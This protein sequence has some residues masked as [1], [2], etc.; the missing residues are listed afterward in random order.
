[1]SNNNET[2]SM[3]KEIAKGEKILI[4]D[5]EHITKETDVPSL[6][7]TG[8]IP[9]AKSQEESEDPNF[10]LIASL[11]KPKDV[12]MSKEE[13][14]KIQN[15]SMQRYKIDPHY[16]AVIDAFLVFIIGKGLQ[17]SVQDEN[18]EVQDY[19]NEFLAVN[20]FNGRDRQIIS[21]V[22]KTGECFVRIFTK[23]EGKPARIPIV[24]C[25]NYWQIDDVAIDQNDNE[26]ILNYQRLYRDEK[27][28]LKTEVISSNEMM[29]FKFGDYDDA[30]GLPP[31]QVIARSC[32]YYSDWLMNRIVFNRL[33]TS[34]YLEEIVDGSPSAVTTQDSATPDQDRT[35]KSGKVVKRMPKFGS[36]LSHNKAVEYKWL[37]PDVKADDA[38]EDGRAIR[39][40]ICAGAQVPEFVLGDASNANYSSTLVAQNPFIRKIE[41]FQDFFSEYFKDLFEWVIRYGVENKFLSS[42]SIETITHERKAGFLRRTKARLS[43]REQVSKNGDVYSQRVVPTKTGVKIQWPT[44]VA[45]NVLQDTQAAQLQQSMEI[46]SKETIAQ[47][48]GYNYQDELRKIQRENAELDQQDENDEEG[49]GGNERE[50]EIKRKEESDNES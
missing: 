29:F 4:T 10:S 11:D 14:L 12:V 34:Y 49:F 20:K 47:K 23:N 19:L 27:D 37:S 42:T 50:E 18:P 30:R 15:A 16:S 43:L 44:L 21:K 46:V 35:S 38:K 32:Q 25:V 45:Q 5:I 9:G 40:S 3:F 6:Y 2:D 33:K 39:L 7:L 31:F 13:R 8:A 17:V 36:K 22:L 28:E 24:R 41:F 48:L 1:M 26:K